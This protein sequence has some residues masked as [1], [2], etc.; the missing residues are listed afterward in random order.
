MTSIKPLGAALVGFGR[1]GQVH[2]GG[3]RSAQHLVINRYPSTSRADGGA[4]KEAQTD[5]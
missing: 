2:H 3:R 4:D 1:I 5:G